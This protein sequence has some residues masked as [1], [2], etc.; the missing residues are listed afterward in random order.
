MRCGCDPEEGA[1]TAVDMV[2][3]YR[4]ALDSDLNVKSV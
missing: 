4:G 3:V 1:A 2:S